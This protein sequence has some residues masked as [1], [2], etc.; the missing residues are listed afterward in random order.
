MLLPGEFTATALEDSPKSGNSRSIGLSTYMLVA[1]VAG[2]SLGLELI[3]TRILSF[4]YYNHVAY[5]TVTVALLGFGI[6][7]VLVSLFSSRSLHPER[8][9]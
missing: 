1:C 4:L 3:Q 8:M 6:S 2:S 5:I 7:G 9:I